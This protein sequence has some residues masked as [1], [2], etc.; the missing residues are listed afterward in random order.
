[1]PCGWYVEDVSEISTVNSLKLDASRDVVD[2]VEQSNALRSACCFNSQGKSLY[3][4]KHL[5]SYTVSQP[6]K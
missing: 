4:P 3:S 6:I 5:P 2:L 1:M